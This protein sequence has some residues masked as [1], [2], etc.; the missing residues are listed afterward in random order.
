MVIHKP[1]ALQTR[2]A[3]NIVLPQQPGGA[4]ELWGAIALDKPYYVHKRFFKNVEAANAALAA[5]PAA[6][7]RGL[8]DLARHTNSGKPARQTN[9]GPVAG[10]T[11]NRTAVAGLFPEHDDRCK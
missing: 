2:F 3:R 10:G 5:N 6:Q 7:T 1:V 9:P 11:A 8:I 4:L